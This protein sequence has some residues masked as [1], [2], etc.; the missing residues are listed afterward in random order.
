[1]LNSEYSKVFVE[2]ICYRF[3]WRIRNIIAESTTVTGSVNTH[4]IRMLLIVPPCNHHFPC[5]YDIVPAIPDER[6][7]V[8][9]TGSPS[10]DA[11][12]I[13]RAVINAHV[14]A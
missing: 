8:V 13:V 5:S 2:H 11:E 3:F 12:L 14:V 6:I 10:F 4:A 9:E 1:M 7:W